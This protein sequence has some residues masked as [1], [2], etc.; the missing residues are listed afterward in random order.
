LSLDHTFAVVFSFLGGERERSKNWIV[1]FT[2]SSRTGTRIYIFKEPDWE[3]DFSS[4]SCMEPKLK[5]ELE[6]G[7]LEK[8]NF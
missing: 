7:F 8:K 5:L 3:L 6:L 4:D 1:V 2:N